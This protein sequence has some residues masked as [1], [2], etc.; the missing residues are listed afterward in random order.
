MAAVIFQKSQGGIRKEKYVILFEDL[1]VVGVH[2]LKRE[3]FHMVLS[4]Q[5]SV[6]E[7]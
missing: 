6:A 7:D 3:I 4:T 1:V 5:K 2:R